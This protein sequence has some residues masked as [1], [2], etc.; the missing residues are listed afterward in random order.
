M[1]KLRLAVAA[2]AMLLL[3][4]GCKLIPV[5]EL[6]VLPAKPPVSGPHWS[7]LFDKPDGVYLLP[8]GATS[9]TQL[10]PQTEDTRVVTWDIA[11]DGKRL[12]LATA[13]GDGEVLALSPTSSVA[14]YSD[15]LNAGAFDLSLIHI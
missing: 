6:K 7:L 2:S 9:P 8:E 13:N 14:L 1:G 4:G 5:G 3:L 12:A 15:S 11:P 10:R